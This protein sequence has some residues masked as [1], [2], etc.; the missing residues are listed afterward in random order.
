MR[1]LRLSWDYLIILLK[2]R[3]AYR[4]D[5]LV[6]VGSDLLLQAVDIVFLLV[7]FSRVDALGGWT[8]DEALFIYG[9]FLIPFALP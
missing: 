3:L 5:F 7:V 1:S 4:T 6:Q 8:F 2:A 9:F